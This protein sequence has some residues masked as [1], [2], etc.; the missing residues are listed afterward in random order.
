MDKV[1]FNV[2]KKTYDDFRNSLII[3]INNK[4]K[5]LFTQ[6]SEDCYL[7]EESWNDELLKSLYNSKDSSDYITLPKNFTFINNFNEIIAHLKDGKKL[8]LINKQIIDLLYQNDNNLK[9]I[10]I[11]KYCGGNNKLIIEYKNK[12]DNKALLLIDP[13]YQDSITNRI[14]ILSINNRIRPSII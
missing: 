12:I 4:D 3:N 9:N 10:P 14:F 11:I 8:K 6:N 5:N 2:I 13:L 1:N 7:I